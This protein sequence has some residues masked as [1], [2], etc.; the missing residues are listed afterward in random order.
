MKRA[1]FLLSMLVF[2]TIARAEVVVTDAT[3]NTVRLPQAAR[4]IVSLAPHATELLFA[5]GAGERVS[6]AVEYSDYPEAARHIPRVGSYAQL[7]FERIV[8]LRPD[9]IVAWHGGNDAA[10]VERLRASGFAIYLSDPHHLEDVAADLERLGQLTGT[11]AIA[12]DAARAFRARLA[13]LRARYA[14]RP[15]VRVFY[16]IWDQPLM[17]VNGE[18]LIS[19]VMRICGGENVFAGLPLLAGTVDV[20]AVLAA[21]P[22]VVVAGGMTGGGTERLDLWKRWPT[23]LAVERGNLFALPADLLQRHAPR[24]LDGAEQ[25]CAALELA[26]TRRPAR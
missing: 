18:H 17:T 7:D 23:L 25:L 24:V 1:A 9:L 4:R 13:A 22:E 14:R 16:Q 11:E 10:A 26:R 21:N 8:A 19:D 15:P 20:E 12:R 2:S 5:A 3:G 6:G